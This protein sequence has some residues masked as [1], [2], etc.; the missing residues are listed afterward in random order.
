M[1]RVDLDMAEQLDGAPSLPFPGAA[2]P[3]I[4][5]L[6]P[7][8]RNQGAQC[9]E[10]RTGRQ[11]DRQQAGVFIRQTTEPPARPPLLLANKLEATEGTGRAS[12]AIVVW[13]VPPREAVVSK[14]S[15]LFTPLKAREQTIHE[16]F[17]R[18]ITGPRVVLSERRDLLK[19]L[20]PPVDESADPT[21]FVIRSSG[22][23]RRARMKLD[24][25]QHIAGTLPREGGN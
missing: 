12:A 23:S 10:V 4:S 7:D 6:P 21:A 1:H 20:L 15:P 3:K 8:F 19:E 14:F 17:G 5:E 22:D 16:P 24:H 13:P 9:S 25:T 18:R 11:L 2:I